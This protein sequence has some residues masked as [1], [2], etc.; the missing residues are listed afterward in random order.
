MNRQIK[1]RA[2]DG[3][4]MLQ[5]VGIHPHLM[6]VLTDD[7]YLYNEGDEGSVILSV[8]N[9][10]YKIMQFTG[11]TDKNGKEIY[12]GDIVEVWGGEQ[13]QG[14]W[15]ISIRGQFVSS[16][17]S[18]LIKDKKDVHYDPS[19]FDATI[20]IIGNIYENPELTQ[21]TS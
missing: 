5:N 13:A 10:A 20:Q 3:E 15:E 7:D 1:F 14:F 6:M 4:Q 17:N 9:T 18:F 12:E 16:Y 2:W 8:M 21:T 11:L 19:M